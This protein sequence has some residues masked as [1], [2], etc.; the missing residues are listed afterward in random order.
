MLISKTPLRLSLAGGG[1][2]IPEYYSKYC[3]NV[4]TSAIDKHVYILLKKWFRPEIRISYSKTEIVNDIKKIQHPMIR[5]VFRYFKLKSHIEM[6]I[7]ADLPA[8]TGLGSSS[9][10]AVGLINIL[11]KYKNKNQ[12]PQS[13]AEAAFKLQ[14]DILGES[15]GKQDQYA[16]S[17][18]GI[19][20][21]KINRNG[22]VSVN[23]LS[24][25]PRIIKDLERRLLCF[26][27]GTQRSAPQIQKKYCNFI[28]NDRSD[29]I[30]SLHKIKKLVLPMIANLQK[31]NVDEIG[32]LFEEHW[33]EKI[34]LSKEVTNDRFNFW[35][36]EAIK[37]GAIGGK[38]LGAGGG[39]YLVFICKENKI[40]NVKKILRRFGLSDI[41][42]KF[43]NVGSTV[44]TKI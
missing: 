35:H 11:S 3:S 23:R 21:M 6:A 39:G 44:L 37:A 15:G 27:T 31:G 18:G 41:P 33:T 1:T 32:H 30:D 13:L 24:I 42:L 10:F 22:N 17:F 38:L 2:D 8:R 25:K 34:N 14:H 16:A 12:N 7:M 36:D 19:I 29:I 40:N 28:E 43:D 20:S 26:Y 5:E 9:S 4:V